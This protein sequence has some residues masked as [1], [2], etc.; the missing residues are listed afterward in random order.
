MCLYVSSTIPLLK[1][2]HVTIVLQIRHDDWRHGMGVHHGQAGSDLSQQ[3]SCD[4]ISILLPLEG[5]AGCLGHSCVRLPSAR[6]AAAVAY[7]AGP[8]TRGLG[9]LPMDLL[10]RYRTCTVGAC[11]IYCR[12]SLPR[13]VPD[14]AINVSACCQTPWKSASSSALAGQP[15]PRKQRVSVLP[16]MVNVGPVPE[17]RQPRKRLDSV[18]ACG[19][20]TLNQPSAV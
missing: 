5:V 6:R 16:C 17:H 4:S 10:G 8:V 13:V 7:A 18:H 9:R 20:I 3:L 15:E 14:R 12:C 19:Q 2:A 1:C 11:M